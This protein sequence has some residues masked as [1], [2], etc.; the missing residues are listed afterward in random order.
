MTLRRYIF[1]LAAIAAAAI[2][3]RAD[4]ASFELIPPRNVIEGRNFSLTFRLNNADASEPSAP[5]LNGCEL[6]Y[7]PAVSTMQSTQIVNGRLSSSRTIDFTF[8]FRAV[9]AGT[10]QVPAVSIRSD[11]GTLHSRPATFNILPRDERTDSNGGGARVDDPSTQRPGQISSD[12]LLVRVFF[13]KNSVYEQEPVVATIKVYTKFDI[14][15]FIPVVQPA[16]EGFLTEELPTEPNVT[17]E[18]YN[19]QN[20]HSA[21][22]KR[23]LLYPQHSGRLSVNSGKY[24]VSIVQYETI[25][26][27]FYRTSRPVERQ[28]TTTSNAA[29]IQVNPLPTPAPEGFN[30]AVGQFTVKTSLEPELM[31]TNEASV[32]SYTV[33]GTGNIKYLPSAP[34]QFPAG[35]ESYTPRTDIDAHIINGGSDMSGKFTTDFTIVPTEVGNFVI[36]GCPMVYFD[37]QAGEYRTAAV[38]DMPIRVLRGTSASAPAEPTTTNHEIEDILHIHPSDINGQNK[39]IQYTFGNK[40]YWLAY[41]LLTLSLIGIIFLY[42]RQIRLNADASGRRLA[43]AG[44]VAGKR[45]KAAKS[46]MDSHK[47]N[48]FY[49]ALAAAMWGYLSDKLS[50]PSSQLTRDNIAEKLSIFGLSETQIQDMLEVLDQ[51]EMARFTPSG[52][53]EQMADLYNKASQ[54]VSAMENVKKK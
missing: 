40:L 33:S 18:H 53:D 8:T 51:C 45:L 22:L 43:K 32:Y 47:S 52:S 24:D 46:A 10:V 27:G 9:S 3:C 50:I 39:N 25:N 29:A 2:G 5:E 15:S 21:V 30:G 49:E 14:S 44:R 19:G 37:P 23:L 7:G 11:Q 54:V 34:V 6:L 38:E 36:E 4:E 41:I 16:F 13:S 48:R 35:I 17:I 12:D 42:R 1:V 20:Y 28:I 26:M 31:R